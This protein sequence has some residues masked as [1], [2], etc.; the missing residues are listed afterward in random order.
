MLRQVRLQ[1]F[2]CFSD[3]TVTFDETTVAV[4]KN[5]AGKSTLIEALRVLAAVVNRRGGNFTPVPGWLRQSHFMVCLPAGIS[6]LDFDFDTLFHRYDPPPAKITASFT[7]GVEVAVYIG[8]DEKVYATIQTPDRWITSPSQMARL[9]LPWIYILPQI[10]PVQREEY[11]LTDKHITDH[12]YSRL[13]SRHFR[14]QVYRSPE[15]FEQFKSLAENTWPSLRVEEVESKT[16][17]QGTLL[18]MLVKDADFVAEIGWMG[19]GLQMWLQTIWFISRTPRDGVVILDEPDVYMHP[20]LQ[21]KL[22][23]I[24]K[25]RF[26]Q[27]IV[28]THSV[29]IM[30][31]AEPNNILV[32]DKSKRRSQYTNSEPALQLL[33]DQ[34]GG[35]H[36]VHLARL[37]N[38]RKFL[39][40]EG[41]DLTLLRHIHTTLFPDVELPLEAIPNI[42]I[43]GWN[44]WHY[45]VGSSMILRNAFGEQILTYC[46][47]D[48]D[49]HTEEEIAERKEEAEVRGVELY[50]WARKE[51]ENYLLHSSAIRRVIRERTRNEGTPSEEEIA[52]QLSEIV[53]D[54]REAVVYDMAENLLS[55]NRKL[56]M[57]AHKNAERTVNELWA[58][59]T[60]RLS[61]VSGKA[62]LS[63]LSQ[64]SQERGGPAF[65]APAVARRLRASEIP[66][67]MKQVLTAIMDG[68]SFESDIDNASPP[69]A[70]AKSTNTKP[71]AKGRT[72]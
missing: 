25:N 10:S 39:L 8:N 41:K 12:L 31:E 44:G 14:N 26:V 45:A 42:A 68:L 33:I 60:N 65:G 56:G 32:I 46:I 29:E 4:G 7:T 43:G 28:A 59:P 63:K 17:K 57:T 47:L 20:D 37:W 62:V 9:G 66:D 21:R 52:K 69:A 27:S 13:A 30:A 15:N 48:R 35:I 55:L 34:I 16:T 38:A 22:F 6:H 19:H 5:N 61:L 70:N 23:R 1:N 71:R 54:Q 3:H 2:R 67:E 49:Y 24:I 50:V 40:L 53:N 18:S 72:A 36:N 11:V 58:N 64:W 51:I